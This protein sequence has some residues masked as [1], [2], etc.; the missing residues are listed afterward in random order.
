MKKKKK[1]KKP[2]KGE[3][4]SLQLYNSLL[5]V[6]R[7]N[8]SQKFNYKQLSK[9]LNIKERGIKM[10]IVSLMKEMDAN[11][12]IREEGGGAYRLAKTALAIVSTIKNANTRGV[13]ANI[14]NKIVFSK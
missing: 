4:S 1:H 14:D 12:I 6:F 3:F 11:G 9:I 2:V 10:Q 13:Y 7:K 8:P 5:S